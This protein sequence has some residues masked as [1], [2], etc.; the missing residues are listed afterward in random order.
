MH[1]IGLTHRL[2]QVFLSWIYLA[3]TS[4]IR[5]LTEFKQSHKLS[6]YR[7]LTGTI[8][9]FVLLFFVVTVVVLLNKLGYIE[10]PWKW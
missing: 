10:W 9:F 6:M 3:L 5:I 4:T 1:C 2:P 8:Y 7:W